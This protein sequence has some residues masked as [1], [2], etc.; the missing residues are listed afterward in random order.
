[1]RR[2]CTEWDR[3]ESGSLTDARWKEHLWTCRSCREEWEARSLLAASLRGRQPAGLRPDFDARLRA[4]LAASA[5]S[6]A[7]HAAERR[8]LGLYWVL[9]AA[10]SGY[11]LW[12]VGAASWLDG[13]LVL[14]GLA[15]AALL[16]S[17][18]EL[19]PGRVFRDMTLLLD[20]PTPHR[21][22]HRKLQGT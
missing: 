2:I 19:V 3:F 8:W 17:L 4:R 21:L 16:F 7:L 6:A 15:G 9:A 12:V 20:A 11:I 13:G 1:M 22:A 18:L 5:P 14:Y 10:V